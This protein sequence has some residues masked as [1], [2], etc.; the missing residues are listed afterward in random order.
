MRTQLNAKIKWGF[1][2][3]WLLSLIIQ[4]YCTELTGDEAYYWMYAQNLDWGYF[5]HPPV[6]AFLIKI[7]YFI[8]GNELGVRLLPLILSTLTILLMEQIIQP[9]SYLTFFKIVL[10]IG[11]L[12]FSGF[13]ATPDA[14]LLMTTALFLWVYKRF[15]NS[16]SYGLGI[17]LGLIIAAMSLS[18]YHGLLILF[19]V[20]LSNFKLLRSTHFWTAI[21]V[22]GIG[23]LPHLFWQISAGFPS[24]NYHLFERSTNPYLFSYTSDFFVT[25]LFVLGPL[26]GI[27]F[28]IAAVNKKYKNQFEKTLQFIFWGGYI[29]FFIASFKGRVEGHWTY[30]TVLPALYFGYH[31]F[32]SSRKNK[33]ILNVIF[34]ISLLIIISFRVFITI[35]FHSD[36]YEAISNMNGRY[37][38]KVKMKKIQDQVGQ[39]PVAFMN[40][41]QQASLYSFY[42]HSNSFS[43]NNIMGRKNQF[44]L[45][46]MEAKFRGQTIAIIPNYDIHDLPYIVNRSDTTYYA[47]VENFQSYSVITIQPEGLKNQYT[48]GQKTE[49]QIQFSSYDEVNLKANP[50]FPSIVYYT[51]F[52]GN[53]LYQKEE[54]FY[55]TNEMLEQKHTVTLKIP[56]DAG[57]YGLYFNLKTGWFPPSYN[58]DRFEV[59]VEK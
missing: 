54:C 38:H 40:S 32:K 22:A 49:I 8:F 50:N 3:F 59:V 6:I 52:K 33:Q 14:P 42:T 57:T 35:D 17:I 47:K 45:W 15:L 18:K 2:T 41:Y 37:H 23:L 26:I 10:S 12:H 20:V 28:F 34:S 21:L 51:Y 46:N 36:Q 31:W 29:F 27:F 48:K 11:I 53:Q 39:T 55:L 5:D 7:G 9:K 44:D 25:Q 58:S 56:E 13:Y 19:L 43:F 16:S 30:F 1:Y 24:V 4:A